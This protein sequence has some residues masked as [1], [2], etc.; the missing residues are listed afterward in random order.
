M[1]MEA[2]RIAVALAESSSRLTLGRKVFGGM[3]VYR[4]EKGAGVL[5]PRLAH[6]NEPTEL[7]L[8]R[9]LLS[10]AYLCFTRHWSV[11]L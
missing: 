10:R 7:S 9:L 6:F 3:G 2:W 11:A 8:G 4:N 5:V 1:R